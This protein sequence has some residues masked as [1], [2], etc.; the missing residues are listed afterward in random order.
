M[1]LKCV[2]WAARYP[3]FA[4][5]PGQSGESR[6]RRCATLADGLAVA[7]RLPDTRRTGCTDIRASDTLVHTYM[8]VMLCCTLGS[9]AR[10]KGK[11][12][13]NLIKMQANVL[14]FKPAAAV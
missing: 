6:L 11:S 12:K 13:A 14:L 4:G 2:I 9:G 10:K 1:S 8:E 3:R 7:R 5:K